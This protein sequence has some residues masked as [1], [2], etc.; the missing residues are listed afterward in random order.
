MTISDTE[1]ALSLHRRARRAMLAGLAALNAASSKA[2][3]RAIGSEAVHDALSIAV[4]RFVVL[5]LGRARGLFGREKDF[6]SGRLFA[7]R[8][9]ALDVS[10]SLAERDLVWSF[11]ALLAA[12][13]PAFRAELEVGLHSDGVD[14]GSCPAELVGNL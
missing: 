6:A 4:L 13:Q 11:P 1:L 2:I 7:A 3:R 9:V 5:A 10:V 12:A 14:F 8:D